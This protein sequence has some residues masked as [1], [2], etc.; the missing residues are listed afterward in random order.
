MVSELSLSYPDEENFGHTFLCFTLLP[1]R[2]ISS[3]SLCK[4]KSDVASACF[5]AEAN[6]AK[7]NKKPIDNNP[8][9]KKFS[10]VVNHQSNQ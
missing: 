4:E 8:I 9:Y 10:Y 7:N 5:R 1:R 2:I 6:A 3:V